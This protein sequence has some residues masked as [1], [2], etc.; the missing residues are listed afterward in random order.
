[1]IKWLHWYSNLALHQIVCL[2]NTMQLIHCICH[3]LF[4]WQLFLLNILQT[5]C[6]LLSTVLKVTPRT[7][8]LLHFNVLQLYFR[9]YCRYYIAGKNVCILRT[10]RLPEKYLRHMETVCPIW[11]SWNH[12]QPYFIR[13]F[14]LGHRGWIICWIHIYCKLSWKIKSKSLIFS[15]R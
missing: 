14:N 3:C 4:S 15:N 11:N 5:F 12:A 13:S 9:S 10:K 8:L 7:A 1:M 6:R 2:W